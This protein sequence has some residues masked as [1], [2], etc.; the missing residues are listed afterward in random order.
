MGNHTLI[1][2][3]TRAQVLG[4]LSTASTATEAEIALWRLR[5]IGDEEDCTEFEPSHQ[6]EADL[7]GV[8]PPCQREHGAGYCPEL[9]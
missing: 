3:D 4:S 2:D 5:Q 6:D 8:C 1:Q 9:L 7:Y